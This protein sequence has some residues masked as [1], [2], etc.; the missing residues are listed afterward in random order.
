MGRWWTGYTSISGSMLSIALSHGGLWLLAAAWR[1]Q[2]SYGYG[3]VEVKI[4]AEKMCLIA[5]YGVRDASPKAHGQR[6][7]VSS[8]ER[9]CE[10]DDA[11]QHRPISRSS[12][13]SRRRASL[14]RHGPQ[15]LPARGALSN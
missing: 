14:P 5:A 3:L 13:T 6:F 1:L 9:G 2:S 11:A 15:C 12:G 7:C 4:P 8:K 10:H